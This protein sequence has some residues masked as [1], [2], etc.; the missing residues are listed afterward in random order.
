MSFEIT[1]KVA[2]EIASHEGLIREAYKDSVG[3]WTF[4]IGITNASGHQV[5]PRYKDNPQTLKRCLELYVWL[6]ETNY[7]PTVQH[8]FAGFDLQEHEF[9]GALSFHYN[10]GAIARATWVDQWKRRDIEAA[11]RSFMNW[12]KPPEIIPRRE[13]ERDLFFDGV[14]SSD[15]YTTEYQVRKPSYTPDWG[16]AQRVDIRPALDE[17]LGRPIEPPPEPEPPTGMPDRIAQIFAEEAADQV[18]ERRSEDLTVIWNRPAN[19]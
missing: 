1:T 2:Q 8:V 18:R 15:G 17:L 3:V 16:S 11:R 12:S 10:T 4:S 9:G 13:K 6:L 19:G 14:W 7:A 5:Y